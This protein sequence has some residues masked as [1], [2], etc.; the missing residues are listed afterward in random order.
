MSFRA[1]SRLL[2]ILLILTAAMHAEKAE[3]FTRSFKV[4]PA[5]LPQSDLDTT[6]L[7]P[8][9]F[10]PQPVQNKTL[11]QLLEDAGITF[12]EGASVSRGPVG[13]IVCRN[14][15]ENLER[16][17]KHVASLNTQNT[18]PLHAEQPPMTTRVFRIGPAFADNPLPAD[19]TLISP[20]DPYL[21]A[22]LLDSAQHPLHKTA[23]EVLEAAGIPFPEGAAAKINPTTG[24]LSATNTPANLK[25]VEAFAESCSP[26]HPATIAYTLTVIE[27]PGELVRQVTAA[28]SHSAD[29]AAQLALLLDHAKNPGSKV[30]VVGDAFLETK[31][32]TRASSEA[33]RE[34][35]YLS[36]LT[37]DDKSTSVHQEMRPI[38]L[39]LAL[40]PTLDTDGSTIRTTLEIDLHPAPPFGHQVSMTEPISGNASESPITDID[41]A[42]F[43]TEI[44]TSSGS[45]KLVGVTKPVGTPQAKEDILWAAFLTGTAHR[46]ASIPFTNPVTTSQMA[47]A[48]PGLTAAAFNVPDGV[49]ESMMEQPQ[50]L[51]QWFESLGIVPVKKATATHQNGVLH[52]VNTTDNIERIAA[53][54]DD[55]LH[56]YS[57][58]VAFTLHTVQA[59]AAFLRGLTLKHAPLNDQHEMWSAIEAAVARGEATFIDS[60]FLETKSGTQAT[61]ESACEHIYLSEFGNNAKGQPTLAFETRPVGSV[62]R[63][64]PIIGYDEHNV[65]ITFSHEL[66]PSAPVTRQEHFRDPSSKKDFEMP[67]VDFYSSRIFTGSSMIN[68]GLKLIA[69]NKP[70]GRDDAEILWATFLKCDVVPQVAKARSTPESGSKPKPVIDPKAWNTKM[71]HVPHFLSSS[72]YPEPRP[73]ITARNILEVS[74]VSFPTGATASYDHASSVIIVKNTNENLAL[75]DDY[76]KSIT[77][78]PPKTV[79]LNTH[80]LQGPGPLLRRLTAQAASKSDHRAELDALLAAVKTGTVQHLDTTRIETKSG[81]RATTRQ[82]RE[83]SA[84]KDFKVTDKGEPVFGQEKRTIGLYLELEP[85]VGADGITVELTLS[86]EFHTAPPFEHREHLIDTQGH[87]LEFPLTDYFT[88]K[89]TTGITIPSGTA[90][91][92]SL[93]K[94]TGKPEFEKA[95]ILQAIFITCDLLRASE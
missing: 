8:D 44:T 78:T 17:K 21:Q 45:T 42:H 75:V 43:S 94:P 72:A 51:P 77:K 55:C 22:S 69:L 16:L 11:K 95:D 10:G 60:I 3:M 85:T 29:A 4:Q 81:V 5:F 71:Y 2:V 64:E 54:T 1:C 53:L 57:K 41:G 83:H 84:I 12:P 27:G 13:E 38:G 20:N 37:T 89:L 74:G 80:I 73:R 32:D 91:L 30:R 26:R 61:H 18:A 46:A 39:S 90:R 6:K 76:V 79:V 35:Q 63:I 15:E 47:Q 82:G 14:T 52:I 86:N 25:I 92:L 66:H 88:T 7:G 34:H 36:E 24:L 56:R 48:P 67:I 33:G 59:P 93:S 23:R 19:A 87:R 28:A 50:P 9:P 40:E 68:G 65:D 58:T 70:T 49:L 62:F 31:S